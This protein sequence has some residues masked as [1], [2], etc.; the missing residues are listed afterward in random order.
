[1]DKNFEELCIACR[2]GDLP[3]VDK[4]ISTGV[5][6]N[7]VDR[8]DNSPLFLASLCGHEDVV[9]LLLKSG[10]ICD[11][12]RYEGARCIYG[13]LTDSIRDLLLSYDISKAVDMNQPFAT[14]FSSMLN[15]D[16]HLNTFD[17]EFRFL[18]EGSM[19]ESTNETRNLVANDTKS[20]SLK[21]HRFMIQ[22]RC[23]RLFDALCE[24]NAK[25]QVVIVNKKIRPYTLELLL[26]FIYLVPVL[27]TI[28]PT[29]Y[30]DLIPMV[31]QLEME[32]LLDFLIKAKHMTDPSEKS[33]LM[34]AY[35]YKFT[36]TAKTQLA[37]F[38]NGSIVGEAVI[39][40]DHTND[41]LIVDSLLYPAYP[42][43]LIQVRDKKGGIKI[44]PCHLSILTRSDYFK[45]MFVDPFKELSTYH[46]CP[47]DT[48]ILKDSSLQILELQTASTEVF[49]IA[50]RYLYYDESDI[51]WEYAMDVVM[52]SDFTLI[53]RLKS[54]AATVIVQSEELLARF[55]I[56]DILNFAWLTRLERLEQYAAKYVA[57]KLR[58]IYKRKEFKESIIKSSQRIT[59]R[60]ETDTI[61][62]VDDIRF[63]LLEKYNLEP[64]DIP[65]FEEED[66]HDSFVIASG[67]LDYQ[68]DMTLVNEVLQEIGLTI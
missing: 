15:D 63:Y 36:S 1:M 4:L 59:D 51:C 23:P 52:I 2:T 18:D 50:L 38:V 20:I 58:F 40:M 68:H 65:L 21:A 3:N 8:F 27:H 55:S 22:A 17:I 29:D 25:R 60:Q 7:S 12:D 26:K 48:K 6:L 28:K 32:E 24:G 43:I 46:D 57:N 16:L 37:S 9:R 5:N 33:A 49:E 56:F 31:K 10:A 67:Y 39:I 53:D 42:D 14:H 62:F 45:G 11:R 64:D 61:E 35:Q 41:K 54:I 19:N 30:D 66:E 44:Y 47:K 13:A 34:L